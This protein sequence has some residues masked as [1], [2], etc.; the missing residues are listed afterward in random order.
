MILL[1]V[2]FGLWAGGRGRDH[3]GDPAAHR[4][5]GAAA[6]A[7]GGVRGDLRPARQRGAH[8]PLPAGLSRTRRR[9]G[10]RRDDLRPALPGPGPRRAFQHAV[11]DGDGAQLPARSRSAGRPRN[12][13][14]AD[15]SI[16]CWPST[17]APPAAAPRNSAA[18]SRTLPGDQGRRSTLPA[19]RAPSNTIRNHVVRG[20]STDGAALTDRAMRARDIR[21]RFRASESVTSAVQKLLMQYRHRWG[22][23]DESGS[24]S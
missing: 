5:A 2:T 4:G 17:S 7:G 1:P 15:C 24:T 11:P 10:A 14:P 23:H 21:G 9:L 13:S 18:R 22:R 19:E 8:R 3:R 16:S 12:S 6:G 20:D